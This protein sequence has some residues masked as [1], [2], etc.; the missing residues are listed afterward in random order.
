M[1]RLSPT[2]SYSSTFIGLVRHVGSLTADFLS[3]NPLHEPDCALPFL[4]QPTPETTRNLH[5]SLLIGMDIY[6]STLEHYRDLSIPNVSPR[7][8]P[9]LDNCLHA[10]C[11]PPISPDHSSTTTTRRHATSLYMSDSGIRRQDDGSK[12]IPEQVDSFWPA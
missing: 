6:T 10:S 7:C 11:A 9:N 3:V 4:A 5:Q 8:Q 2:L 1:C 12:R